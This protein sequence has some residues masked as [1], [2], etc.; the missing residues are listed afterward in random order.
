MFEYTRFESIPDGEEKLR[1]LK[2]C[3]SVSD[4]RKQYAE[5]LK[6]RFMYI[7]ESVLNDDSFRA[8]IMFPEYM[9]PL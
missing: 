9:S 3:I 5:S 8:V 1:Y 2:K 4:S 7:R 6:L